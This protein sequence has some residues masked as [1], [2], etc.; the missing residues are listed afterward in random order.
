VK[1][2]KIR[3]IENTVQDDRKSRHWWYGHRERMGVVKTIDLLDIKW[4]KV[5]IKKHRC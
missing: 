1:Y 2:R 4:K 5:E 3:K